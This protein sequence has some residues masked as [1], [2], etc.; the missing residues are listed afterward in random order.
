MNVPVPD[1]HFGLGDADTSVRTVA[2]LFSGCGGMDLGFLGDFEF[3]GKTFGTLSN[4]IVFAN[5]ISEAA[6]RTYRQNL[7]H[8]IHAMDIDKAMTHLP[9]KCDILLGGFPCQDVSLNGKRHQVSAPCCTE[10]WLKP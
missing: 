5:D 4:R 10:R 9:K 3:L 8:D 2:S 7:G 6:C 1:S